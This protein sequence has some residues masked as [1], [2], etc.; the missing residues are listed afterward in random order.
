MRWL[1]VGKVAIKPRKIGSNWF[2]FLTC[3]AS[4]CKADATVSNAKQFGEYGGVCGDGHDLRISHN[5]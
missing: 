5:G 2:A 4:Y 1:N 3:P